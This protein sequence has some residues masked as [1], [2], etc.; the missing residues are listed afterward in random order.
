MVYLYFLDHFS[1]LFGPKKKKNHFFSLFPSN[2]RESTPITL[3]SF[4]FSPLSIPTPRSFHPLLPN[5]EEMFSSP[6]Q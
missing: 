5:I 6:K 4:T 1:F 2:I 3:P